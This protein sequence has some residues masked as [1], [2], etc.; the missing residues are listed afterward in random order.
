MAKM[1]KF[2]VVHR[3][4]DISWRE[5]EDNWK[6]LANVE[7]GLWERTWYNKREGVRYCLWRATDAESLKEVFGQ[8]GVGWDSILEVKET[9]PDFWITERDEYFERPL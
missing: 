7:K 4:T 5:V 9:N 2:M 6:E 1:L 3:D 8:L